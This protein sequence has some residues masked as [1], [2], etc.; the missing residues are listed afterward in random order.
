[1]TALHKL[2]L[3]I[4]ED[5]AVVGVNDIPMCEMADPPLTTIPFDFD[6]LAGALIR[7]LHAQLRGQS[8]QLTVPW[9]LPRLIIRDSCG[10]RLRRGD[11]IDGVVADIVSDL[12]K[13]GFGK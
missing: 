3:R 5:V 12:G 7:H 1:M 13:S 9:P 11:R 10:G 2:G 4:P 8:A 6:Y